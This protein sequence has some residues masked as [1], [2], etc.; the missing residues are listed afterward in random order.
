[1]TGRTSPVTDNVSQRFCASP[2]PPA[3]DDGRALQKV[4]PY[5]CTSKSAINHEHLRQTRLGA[6]APFSRIVVVDS[7]RRVDN[8]RFDQL[9]LDGSQGLPPQPALVPSEKADAGVQTDVVDP[10]PTDGKTPATAHRVD[11]D[12]VLMRKTLKVMAALGTSAEN[13]MVFE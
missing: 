9:N 12:G 1:M 5:S 4:P 2:A 6:S 11:P 10:P 13:P 3:W 8:C 7:C